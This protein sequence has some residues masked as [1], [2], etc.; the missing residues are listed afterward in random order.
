VLVRTGNGH[1]FNFRRQLSARFR[2]EVAG[3]RSD[4]EHLVVQN[5]SAFDGGL[6]RRPKYLPHDRQ[7]DRPHENHADT[8][9]DARDRVDFE[10][11]LQ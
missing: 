7:Y 9:D 1:T 10:K 8:D 3:T 6:D 4:F 5:H 2:E 11:I